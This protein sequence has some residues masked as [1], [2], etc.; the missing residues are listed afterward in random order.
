M[1]LSLKSGSFEVIFHE[2]GADTFDA[3]EK[4]CFLGKADVVYALSRMSLSHIL[5]ADTNFHLPILDGEKS[6]LFCNYRNI[7][8][9]IAAIVKCR[10]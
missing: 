8:I 3:P 7:S 10:P 4:L 2:T 5:F 6:F 1:P 9:G